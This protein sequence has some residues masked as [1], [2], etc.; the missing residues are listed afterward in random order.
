MLRS[1]F[2]ELSLKVHT[3]QQGDALSGA[4]EKSK[5]VAPTQTREICGKTKAEILYK[6]LK[7]AGESKRT[8]MR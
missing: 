8:K 3:K 5:H 2:D 6:L 4:L 7:V 1:S